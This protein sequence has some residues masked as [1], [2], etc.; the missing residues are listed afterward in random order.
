MNKDRLHAR[1]ELSG[2]RQV[3]RVVDDFPTDIPI[4]AAELDAVEAFLMP[5][6]N[7]ILRGDQ[8]G[9]HDD[10]HDDLIRMPLADSQAPQ[11]TG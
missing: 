3:W 9:H 5:L 2:D 1:K 4:G 6:V 7:A 8:T 10:D 11:K